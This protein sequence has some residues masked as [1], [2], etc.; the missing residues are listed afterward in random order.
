M[1]KTKINTVLLYNFTLLGGP[2]NV[3]DFLDNK[4]CEKTKSIFVMNNL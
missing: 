2:W 3:E 1:T 4:I